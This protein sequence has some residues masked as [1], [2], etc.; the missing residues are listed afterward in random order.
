MDNNKVY[1][2]GL[3]EDMSTT[4]Q[5]FISNSQNKNSVQNEA[6]AVIGNLENVLMHNFERKNID[7]E[8]GVWCCTREQNTAYF[9]LV[10]RS[11]PDRLSYKMLK[12]LKGIWDDFM[13]N[14]NLDQMKANGQKLLQK[15]NNPSSFD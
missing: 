9:A 7:G 2:C 10:N 4:T 3:S 1:A 15:Y 14:Q 11:Y 8:L 6:Q 13:S 12:E 5:I